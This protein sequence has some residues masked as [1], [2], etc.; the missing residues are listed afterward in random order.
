MEPAYLRSTAGQRLEL[1]SPTQ[2]LT[3][4]RA[5]AALTSWVGSGVRRRRTLTQRARGHGKEVESPATRL[6]VPEISSPSPPFVPIV[7]VWD[8]PIGAANGDAQWRRPETERIRYGNRRS[9]GG[10][11][12]FSQRGTERESTASTTSRQGQPGQGKEGRD[13]GLDNER[14]HHGEVP[15]WL[16]QLLF[17]LG[18][19]A[20]WTLNSAV[21]LSVLNN[22]PHLSSAPV[23]VHSTT[24]LALA[25]ACR[26]LL[27]DASGVEPRFIM[28]CHYGRAEGRAAS[29]P[30][31]YGLMVLNEEPVRRPRDE[32]TTLEIRSRSRLL[33]QDPREGFCSSFYPVRRPGEDVDIHHACRPHRAEKP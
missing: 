28:H 26:L 5:L 10:L 32:D 16:N 4:E 11:S 29:S 12:A 18:E 31:V 8:Q 13:G 9:P 1:A 23:P 22:C 2:W 27:I 17:N 3:R 7:V 14:F 21:V 33:G 19:E 20:P 25:S 30:N 6:S 15:T 24:A